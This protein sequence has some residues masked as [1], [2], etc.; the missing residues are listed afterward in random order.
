[1]TRLI[2]AL[3][4][5]LLFVAPV[6]AQTPATVH[7]SWNPNVAS[8][9]VVQYVITLDSAA[10][11]VVLAATC[12][13][14]TCTTD[15]LLYLRRG[16]SRGRRRK[17]RQLRHITMAASSN[18]LSATTTGWSVFIAALGMMLGLL[19][20]DISQLAAWSHAT[21]PAFVG[22]TIGHLAAT[23]AAFVGGRMIPT[24]TKIG[25]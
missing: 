25:S 21:T 9:N 24:G 11:V 13:A 5:G 8:D 15:G 4:I 10:P 23:I 12:T 17:S 7:A 1:M 16:A 3:F 18:G 14:T 20:V 22:T 6:A 19:A 2:L